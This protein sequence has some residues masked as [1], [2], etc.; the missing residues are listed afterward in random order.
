MK[1]K[2]ISIATVDKILLVKGVTTEMEKTKEQE[3]LNEKSYSDVMPKTDWYPELP[4][5]DIDE[6]LERTYRMTDA[7][8][9]ED[10]DGKFGKSSFALVLLQDLDNG[11]LATCL[12]GGMVVVKKIRKAIEGHMLPL[13]ATLTKSKRYYDLE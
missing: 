4:R 2:G 6:V 7:T 11:D 12:F 13:L 5:L 1:A 3:Q 9:V 10:Y 8:I